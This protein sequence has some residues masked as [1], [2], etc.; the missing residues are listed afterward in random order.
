MSVDE[1]LALSAAISSALNST[2]TE[3]AVQGEGLERAEGKL[4]LIDKTLN[5]AEVRGGDILG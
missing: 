5:T 2:V 1:S 3:A 4:R